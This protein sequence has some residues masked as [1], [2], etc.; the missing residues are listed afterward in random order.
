[1][2]ST[3]QLA[4]YC[5]YWQTTFGASV[6]DGKSLSWA[7]VSE[8]KPRGLFLLKVT[9]CIHNHCRFSF[10]KMVKRKYQ[11]HDTLDVYVG[12]LNDIQFAPSQPWAMPWDAT[13]MF[14]YA[15]YMFFVIMT[16][17]NSQF[18]T[19]DIMAAALGLVTGVFGAHWG[20][21]YAKRKIEARAKKNKPAH[22]LYRPELLDKQ[23]WFEAGRH[24]GV[25]SASVLT[26]LFNID[27]R[28]GCLM[29]PVVLLWQ[30]RLILLVDY[31]HTQQHH[32]KKS[33]EFYSRWR[34]FG[35]WLVE[36]KS[37]PLTPAE[38][39]LS[40]KKYSGSV[41]GEM[42]FHLEVGKEEAVLTWTEGKDF[43]TISNSPKKITISNWRNETETPEEGN[44]T[45]D[46]I[47]PTTL[48]RPRMLSIVEGDLEVNW[49]FGEAKPE[50]KG[51]AGR[52]AIVFDDTTP[53]CLATICIDGENRMSWR[54]KNAA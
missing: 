44:G 13:M 7:A 27:F 10:T 36:Q 33:D 35:N 8:I 53:P 26:V 37:G 28:V 14:F 38:F 29:S 5:W 24:A 6:F 54:Y 50:I 21:K 47:S 34:E 22:P 12:D 20:R 46:V 32:C 9:H 40:Y 19:G 48:D 31:L 15:S 2:H 49:K 11:T 18:T 45:P 41:D 39:V 52:V 23:L 3:E 42:P 17:M 51:D 25:V 4:R 16:I 30:S 1:M 43:A